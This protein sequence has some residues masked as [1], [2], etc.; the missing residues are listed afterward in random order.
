M[1]QPT[2]TRPYRPGLST[3]FAGLASRCVSVSPLLQIH[4]GVRK[5]N[6]TRLRP[7]RVAQVL[8]SSEFELGAVI[9][10]GS[11]GQVHKALHR[12]SQRTLALKV[13]IRIALLPWGGPIND[14]VRNSDVC[15]AARPHRRVRPRVFRAPRDCTRALNRSRYLPRR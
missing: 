13:R 7:L 6:V 14:P 10:R 8:Q 2:S 15:S 1:S 11:V 5:K 9:G 3:N 4:D 12:P